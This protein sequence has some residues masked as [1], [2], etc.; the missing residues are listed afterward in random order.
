MTPQ[1]DEKTIIHIPNVNS[2]ESTLD[3]HKEVE[4]IIETLGTT[5]NHC[6]VR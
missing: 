6:P 4:H 1:P 3:K 2:R 5:T